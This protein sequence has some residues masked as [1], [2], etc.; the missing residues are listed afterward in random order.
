M[1]ETLTDQ[2]GY[3]RVDGLVKG[4]YAISVVGIGGQKLAERTFSIDGDFL[5]GVDIIM[6]PSLPRQ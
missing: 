5:F 3:Y 4:N 2:F 6:P 1:T